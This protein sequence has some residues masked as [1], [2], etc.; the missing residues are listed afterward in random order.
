MSNLRMQFIAIQGVKWEV[1]TYSYTYPGFPFIDNL[2]LQNINNIIF[3]NLSIWDFSANFFYK[4][5]K[6]LK[7]NFQI[8]ILIYNSH[9]Y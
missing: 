3:F 4:Q 9:K 2:K 1:S 5:Y 6:Y 7:I 8:K